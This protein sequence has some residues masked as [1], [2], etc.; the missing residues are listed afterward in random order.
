MMRALFLFV[1][2]LSGC[3]VSTATPEQQVD[4]FYHFYLEAFAGD[5]AE[6]TYSSPTMRRYV[7]AETLGRLSAIEKIEEQ[8][9]VGSDYFIYGQDYAPE[10]IAGLQ[11]GPAAD[12]LGGKVL[13]VRLGREA[14]KTQRLRVYLRR[15]QGLWKL[16]RVRNL[17][18]Q[19]EQPI[20][21]D[22]ALAAAQAHAA[23]LVQ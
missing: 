14:G 9:I 5:S 16:Y 7:A 21:D 10:W 17:S 19:Y 6:S 13:D 22:H 8:Q 18:D 2:L 12:Y 11:V 4:A 3:T 1:L 20:F 23:T 15:E